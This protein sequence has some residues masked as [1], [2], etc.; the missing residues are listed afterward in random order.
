M[1]HLKPYIVTAHL[2]DQQPITI[3]VL[4]RDASDAITIA[5]YHYPTHLISTSILRHDWEDFLA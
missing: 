5:Q 2:K 1:S 4:A 3:P